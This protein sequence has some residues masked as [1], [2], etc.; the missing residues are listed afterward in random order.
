EAA[1][2]PQYRRAE[3]WF[4]RGVGRLDA[5]DG[6]EGPQR[7]PQ[8]QQRRAEVRRLVAPA[9]LARLQHAAQAPL[10]LPRAAHKPRPLRGVAPQVGPGPEQ[11]PEQPQ[12]VAPDGAARPPVVDQLLEI[13]LEM[14]PAY[15]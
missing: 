9:L 7:R 2:A 5:G 3:G 6:H 12:R 4:G 10:V 13:A 15:L 8:L 14:R 11:A 1:L